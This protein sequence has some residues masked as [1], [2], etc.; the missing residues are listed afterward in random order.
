MRILILDDDITF[1]KQLQSDL[2]EY[3]SDINSRTEYT[4]VNN[5]FQHFELNYKINIAFIDIDLVDYNGIEL[6]KKIRNSGLCD[7]LIFVTS[8]PH[9]IYDSLVVR[10]FFFIRKSEYKTDLEV[11]FDLI[12]DMFLERKLY[13]LKW[14]K[15]KTIININD[16]IYI[17]SINHMLII[18]TIYGKYNDSRLLK[19]MLAE[20][21]SVNFSQIHK[22][23]VINFKYLINYN[24]T[25]VFLIGNICLQIGRT[26]KQ[27]FVERYEKYLEDGF[28]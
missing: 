11:F 19:T 27:H 14:Q 1:S 5:N 15:N 18:H 6:A 8:H 23:Y 24:T 9:L 16:I 7:M 13:T 25:E 2:F 10:P 21:N 22:S 26:F 20:L 12:K 3:F 4:I 17:E 28:I